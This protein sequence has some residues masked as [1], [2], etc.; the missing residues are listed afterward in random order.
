VTH[1]ADTVRET[2]F[3][4]EPIDPEAPEGW[5]R[6]DFSEFSQDNERWFVLYTNAPRDKNPHTFDTYWRAHRK[7]VQ[8]RF[9]TAW[10]D[11]AVAHIDGQEA[12]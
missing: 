8:E 2:R 7:V 9:V 6:C 5:R 11:V 1:S 3:R 10:Q 12:P 4:W